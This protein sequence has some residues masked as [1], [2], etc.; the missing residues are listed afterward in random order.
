MSIFAVCGA[1]VVTAALALMIRSKSPQSALLLSVA[2]GVVI[3][4]SV[5]KSIPATLSSIEAIF[6]GAG[7]D[8]AELLILLKV[9]GI[10]FITEFTCDCVTEAGLLSLSTNISFAGKIIV[11]LTALPLFE[12]IIDV[13]R[14]LG[15]AG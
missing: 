4:L 10:C 15:G 14:Q 12:R 9:M 6:S 3:L 13:I 8:S 7:V 2:S 5:L 1:A 11:I